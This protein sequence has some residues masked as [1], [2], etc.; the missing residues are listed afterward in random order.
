MARTTIV[1]SV[2]LI[3]LGLGFFLGTGAA[4]ATALI[5]SGFGVL[6]L[7]LGLLATRDAWR[8]HAMHLVALWAC[9]ASPGRSRAPYAA[10]FMGGAWSSTPAWQRGSSWPCSVRRCWRCA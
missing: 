9:W 6:L 7:F 10:R 8:M 1:F 2:L 3:L 5:P 4:H